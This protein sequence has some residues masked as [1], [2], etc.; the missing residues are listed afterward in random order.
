[1]AGQITLSRFNAIVA[2]IAVGRF[3]TLQL[4]GKARAPEL[5]PWEIGKVK[6]PEEEAEL[7]AKFKKERKYH[8]HNYDGRELHVAAAQSK[9][10][11]FEVKLE[12]AGYLAYKASLEGLIS[13]PI[14][15]LEV[16]AIVVTPS[17]EVLYQHRG[18]GVGVGR[19]LICAS[20]EGSV[21]TNDHAVEITRISP[22]FAVV[23]KVF[24]EVGPVAMPLVK[25][26]AVDVK[27]EF[28][29][30]SLDLELS[31]N[32]VLSYHIESH[33]N[34]R[35]IQQLK[36]RRNSSEI[37]DIDHPTVDDMHEYLQRHFEKM[38]PSAVLGT[39]LL[40]LKLHGEAWL[41][42]T[43]ERLGGGN[44]AIAAEGSG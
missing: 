1:M 42:D 16:S 36:P 24:D 11:I 21:T 35:T 25:N 3:K 34:W 40:G 6:V 8:L 10:G 12:I 37:E 32:H 27:G 26:G 43:V 7:L 38:T 4:G 13:T 17:K 28:L 31:R 18:P 29:G 39:F 30:A 2:P 9:N 5:K 20:A 15:L 19:G 14:S 33:F 22:W 23:R 41:K 44:K